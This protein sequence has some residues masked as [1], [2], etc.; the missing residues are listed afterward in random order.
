MK[1]ILAFI[2]F[3]AL[4]FCAYKV[5]AEP[6]VATE[7]YEK[8]MREHLQN[9]NERASSLEHYDD[10]ADY[11]AEAFESEFLENVEH[12]KKRMPESQA[13]SA[14]YNKLSAKHGPKFKQAISQSHSKAGQRVGANPFYDAAAQFDITI[15]R[16]TINIPLPLTVPMFASMHFNAK[17][18]SIMGNYLPNGVS[19]Q[20]IAIDPLGSVVFTLLYSV[21][22]LTDTITVSCTQV[23]YITFLAALNYNAMRLSKVRYAISDVTKLTQFNQPFEVYSKTIF[24]KHN[25][26]GISLASNNDPKSLNTGV[27]D[28]DN[29][30]D[31]DNSTAIVV[32]IIPVAAF[33]VTL[34]AF[35]NSYSRISSNG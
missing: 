23:P 15:T 5:Y 21:T 28:I 9:V 10:M 34:S 11:E 18:L 4:C 24:G 19:I 3:L 8:R 30:I 33:S 7:N 27:R 35:V 12:F 17:Y 29:S 2:A 1:T 20:S 13:R 26:N 16:N 14:A 22:G 25:G 31:V 6:T 32:G